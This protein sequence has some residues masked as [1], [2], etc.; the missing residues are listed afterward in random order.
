MLEDDVGDQEG[1]EA[2]YAII[3]LEELRQ[4]LLELALY[5][6][7]FDHS[8]YLSHPYDLLNL[9]YPCKASYLVDPAH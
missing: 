5:L 3:K 7:N 1:Y 6:E 4:M 8:R 9:A 2:D